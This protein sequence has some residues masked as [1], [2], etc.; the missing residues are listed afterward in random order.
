MIQ[1]ISYNRHRIFY[2]DF[3]RVIAM[4]TVIIL[5]VASFQ[6]TLTKIGSLEWN[7]LNFFDS[8]ARWCVPI[9][10]MISGTLFLNPQKEI[11]LKSIYKK[12]IPRILIMLFS[13]NMLYAI[14]SC[15]FSKSFIWSEFIHDIFIGQVHMWYL[16]MII[17]LYMIIPFLRKIV[18][19]EKLF[20][21]FLLLWLIVS[22]FSSLCKIS[23]LEILSEIYD[24]MYIT[25][26]AGYSGYFLLGYFLSRK[27]YSSKYAIILGIISLLITVIGTYIFSINRRDTNELFYANLSPNVIGMSI[28]V[29]ILIKN[30]FENLKV[31]I[32]FHKIIDT[33]AKYSLGI[34]LIH[35]WFIAAFIKFKNVINFSPIINLVLITIIVF[36]LS[37]IV[38]FVLSKIKFL[39]HI[40]K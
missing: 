10:I 3:L 34:Y 4:F 2:L 21:Y 20:K 31:N 25:L 39:K 8:F 13:W 26:V 37:F 17:G 6:M 35:F 14:F 30:T 23:S 5:H 16:Y 24:D 29:F 40:V 1:D 36:L 33:I 28:S 12:Y 18:T 22:T 19:D 32:S 38:T 7:F 15:I 11:T 9:F 27:K